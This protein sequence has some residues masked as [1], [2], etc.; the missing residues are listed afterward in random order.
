MPRIPS[1]DDLDA[2]TYKAAAALPYDDRERAAAGLR[3]QLCIMAIA[4][5]ATPDWSTLEIAGPTEMPGLHGGISWFE[6][7]GSVLTRNS[8]LLEEPSGARARSD[9]SAEQTAPL[10]RGPTSHWR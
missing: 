9:R 1:L 5:R 6:W 10:A 3:G 4:G 2:V 7:H 8:E